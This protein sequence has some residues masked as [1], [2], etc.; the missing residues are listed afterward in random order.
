MTRGKK[1]N[2]SKLGE[3]GLID[4]LT[5]NLPG[6]SKVVVKGIGDDCAVYK[7]SKDRYQIITTDAL[8]EDVHF[9]LANHPPRLLGR[10]SLAVSLS[11]IAAMGGTPR[12]A[13]ISLGIPKSLPLAFL[14]RF[15]EGIHSICEEFNICIAG[16]DTVR[17]PKGF[18]VSLTLIGEVRKNRLFVRSGAKAGHAIMVTGTLGDSALGLKLLSKKKSPLKAS[19]AARK[20]LETRHL[21]PVPRLEFARSLAASKIRVSSMIDISDGLEQDLGHICR[22]SNKGADLDLTTIPESRELKILCKNNDLD[23]NPFCLT[24]GEDYELLFT[25]PGED[26]KKLVNITLKV[27]VPVTRIGRMT[28]EKGVIRLLKENESPQIRKTSSGFDHFR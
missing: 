22:Q 23:N 21:D 2:L 25:I 15:Y 24:G 9:T 18:W 20:F 4:R 19:K 11:D 10:K 28:S 16:G 26:V 3:F 12:T 17:S 1:T 7:S 14:D 8:V 5:G 6:N 27:G 13:V